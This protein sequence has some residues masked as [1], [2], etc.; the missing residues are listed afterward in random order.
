MTSTTYWLDPERSSVG[1][2][3]YACGTLLPTRH[4]NPANNTASSRNAQHIAAAASAAA[5]HQRHNYTPN[6]PSK[7]IYYDMKQCAATSSP[8][9]DRV[10][11]TTTDI[12]HSSWHHETHQRCCDGSLPQH[13][14]GCIIFDS[15]ATFGQ[16]TVQRDSVFSSSF[17]W[18][19]RF[20]SVKHFFYIPISEFT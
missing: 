16:E 15:M 5:T 18:L 10:D 9:Y 11:S 7:L 17:F 3:C 20:I 1:C 12:M 14:L 2:N 8:I 4:A 19:L 6:L 13:D